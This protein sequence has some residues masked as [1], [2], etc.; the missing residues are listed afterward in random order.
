[1]S[2]SEFKHNI[3]LIVNFVARMNEENVPYDMQKIMVK[4]YANTL[5]INLT[6]RMVDSITEI[7]IACA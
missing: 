4:I 5:K 6:D 1:M 2:I 3:S 7:K